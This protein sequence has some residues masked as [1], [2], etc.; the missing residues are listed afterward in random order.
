[1]TIFAPSLRFFHFFEIPFSFSTVFIQISQLFNS[2]KF[3]K[4]S[5]RHDDFHHV[6][7]FQFM[8]TNARC[9]SSQIIMIN[10]YGWH[11]FSSLDVYRDADGCTP[12]MAAVRGRSYH[13]GLTL[14]AKAQ[15]LATNENGQL[16]K[17]TFMAMLYPTDSHPDASPLY[18]LCCNDTCSFTWTGTEHINQDIF[19]CRTC[20]LTGSLCCCT[21]CARVCHRGHDCKY[22]TQVA[23]RVLGSFLFF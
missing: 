1:M 10:E 23:Q 4:L 15:S 2:M 19:E 13:A 7:V 3:S 9:S 17:S 20:G 5:S 14:F 6:P 8:N 22:V 12:F 16:D 21:E 11:F 18:M